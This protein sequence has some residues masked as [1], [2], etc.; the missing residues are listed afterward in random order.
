MSLITKR[1][2]ESIYLD[3]SNKQYLCEKGMDVHG[4]EGAKVGSISEVNGGHFV[5]KKG[6][7]FPNDFYIPT[8]AVN[9]VE[10]NKVYLNV[11]KDEA[12]SQDPSWEERPVGVASTGA[13]APSG[14]RHRH[15]IER[16]AG[17]PGA[18][19]ARLW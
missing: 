17:R 8:S 12:M 16:H 18:V 15:D 2:E 1:A 5:V 9:S 14:I 4:S 11:T 13:A 6:F 3:G 7:F 10:D 19:R